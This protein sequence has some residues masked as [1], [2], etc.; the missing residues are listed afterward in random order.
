MPGQVFALQGFPGIVYIIGSE[1][2]LE[3]K[4]EH[5]KNCMRHWK[6]PLHQKAKRDKGAFSFISFYF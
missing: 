3:L 1:Q 2:C 5:W 6:R 4:N